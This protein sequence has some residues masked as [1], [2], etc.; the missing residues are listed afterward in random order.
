[1]AFLGHDLN[2]MDMVCE[3]LGVSE[4]LIEVLVLVSLFRGDFL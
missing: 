1:M 2:S 4:G 3:G